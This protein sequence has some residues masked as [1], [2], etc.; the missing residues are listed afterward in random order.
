MADTKLTGRVVENLDETEY[1]QHP[2][3]SY[4]AGKH[5]LRSPAHYLHEL[6]NRTEKKAYDVGH[7]VHAKVLGV[8]M[9]VAVIPN[10]VLSKSGSTGTAAAKEFIEAARAAGQVPLKAHEAERVE[11]AAE[12]VLR[13]PYARRYLEVDG[14][15]EVSL[16]A[17]DPD[18]GVDI[19]GR[20]D[21]LPHRVEGRRT[22]PVDLKT[23]TDASTEKIRRIIGD[24]H[25]DVQGHMYRLLI[26]LARGDD[27]G[28]MV[29]IYVETDPPHGVNVVQIADEAWLEGG[30]IKTATIL[31]R[32]AQCV[33][34]NRWPAYA[35]TDVPHPIAP[36]PWYLDQAYSY[37]ES[38]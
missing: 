25:Y 16:F 13:E 31:R 1:H 17:T 12:A 18:T 20:V 19:R 2:A 37:E 24:F 32:H 6:H 10:D 15:P 11:A 27:T 8:G 21:Y 7:A 28:P 5:Y 30:A 34:E 29:Q 23:T 38:P 9:G 35:L 22:I 4:S 14:A 36:A 3:L 33:A 26:K